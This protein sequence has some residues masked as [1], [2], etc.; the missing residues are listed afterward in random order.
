MTERIEI[1]ILSQLQLHFIFFKG[2]NHWQVQFTLYFIPLF[3][4]RQRA[5][6]IPKEI[7]KIKC[8]P[9]QVDISSSREKNRK[10]I[11]GSG[12]RIAFLGLCPNNRNIGKMF[13]S[14]NRSVL[15]N[16]NHTSVCLLLCNC[17]SFT[18]TLVYGG[19][20]Q[21]QGSSESANG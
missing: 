2:N 12:Y 9:F 15:V 4:R 16:V 19:A 20:E 7:K 1:Y 10:G 18:F 3:C 6:L 21:M 17:E 8:N 11:P 13:D 14:L 5:L